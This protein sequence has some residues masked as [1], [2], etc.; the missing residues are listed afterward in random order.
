[1]KMAD[2]SFILD[3]KRR[4]DTEPG[5]ERRKK[6]LIRRYERMKEDYIEEVLFTGTEFLR[7]YQNSNK[8]EFYRDLRNDNRE[9]YV[10]TD[11]VSMSDCAKRVFPQWLDLREH[12]QVQMGNFIDVIYNCPHEIHELVSEKYISDILKD[13]KPEYKEIL[14]YEELRGYT[15]PQIAEMMGQSE[16]NI[17]KKKQRI[18]DHVGRLLYEAMQQRPNLSSREQAFMDRFEGKLNEL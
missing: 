7:A 10:G 2:M 3:P 12:R 11:P 17:R 5:I 1:M 18:I 6:A 16:R 9:E 15:V 13:L 14:F 8:E 4:L